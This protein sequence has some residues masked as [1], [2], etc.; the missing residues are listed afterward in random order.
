MQRHISGAGATAAIAEV[1]AAE[2]PLPVRFT[3]VAPNAMHVTLVGD[4]NAWNPGALPL[5]RLSDGHTWEVQVRLDQGRYAYAF[6]VD[7]RVARDPSAPEGGGDDYGTANSIL[8]V[9]AHRGAGL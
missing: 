9:P 6:V 5:R 7:G 4:F 1:A 2:Q 8:L 3:L